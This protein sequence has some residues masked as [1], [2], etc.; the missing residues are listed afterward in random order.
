MRIVFLVSLW[1]RMR[2]G[3]AV[4]DEDCLKIGGWHLHNL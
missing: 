1:D 2:S 3:S 4:A